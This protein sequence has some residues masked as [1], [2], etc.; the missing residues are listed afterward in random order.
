MCNY[1]YKYNV[2]FILMTISDIFLIKRLILFCNLQ[3]N[4]NEWLSSAVQC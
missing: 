4:F 2:T 3:F 1:N